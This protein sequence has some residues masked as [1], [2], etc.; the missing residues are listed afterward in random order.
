MLGTLPREKMSEWK[1]HI[2]MLVHDYNC[3][4]NSATGFNP[5][6]L[7]FGRQPHLPIDVTLDVAPWTIMEPYT[8]K[9]KQ[10]IGEHT[11]WTH[12]KAEAFQAKEAQCHKCNYDKWGRA[13]ALEVEDTVL[14]HV[15][16]FKGCHKVQDQWENTE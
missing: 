1:N 8:T 10:K 9:F 13:A 12:K 4:W 7:M 3:T 14:V 6:F 15:T 2:G 16:A 5:Y 11:Q